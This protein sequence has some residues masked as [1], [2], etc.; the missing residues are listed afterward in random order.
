MQTFL[1]WPDFD[2]SAEV[3]DRQRLGKQRVETLQI[4][5]ALADPDYGWQSHPAVRMWRGYEHHL[6]RY[7]LAICHAWTGRG[8]RDRC[9]GQIRE[10]APPGPAP[11]EPPWL[12]DEALH[13]SH[14]SNLLRKNPEHYGPLFPD[15]PDDLPYVWPI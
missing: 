12:G 2:R 3:L 4:L 13:R 15:V 10:L 1:P 6:V 9:A 5:R 11:A 8:Y 14:R 7:G